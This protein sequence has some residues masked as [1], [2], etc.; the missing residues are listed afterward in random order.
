M[1]RLS[2]L[3]VTCC[4]LAALALLPAGCSDNDS[5]KEIAV[6]N[7][8]AL[9]QNVFADETPVKITFVTTGAW[10]STKTA[11]WAGISPSQGSEPGSY[12]V[13]LRLVPNATET[14]RA[15][16]ITISCGETDIT[17]N[18]TQKATNSDGTKYVPTVPDNT[19]I[20]TVFMEGGT[21]QMGR[22][23]EATPIHQVTLG[24]FSI[25]KYPVTQGQ[26]KTVMETDIH[27]QRDIAGATS[28]H[29][30]GDNYPMYYVNF[31]D[32]QEFIAELN[33]QTGKNY[34]LPTE[35]EWEYAAR[36]GNQSPEY[37]YSGSNSINDV[38]WHRSNG[39]ESTHPVGAKL[40]NDTG[41]YDMSGNVYEWC[42]DWY[43]TY[44]ASAQTNPAGPPS[45]NTRALRGG[46][47]YYDASDCRV[48]YRGSGGPAYRGSHIG[49][50]IVLAQ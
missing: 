33:R 9:N 46:S 22:E 30:E 45:G 40:P 3:P 25:G 6:Q 23:G 16:A 39:N 44:P 27:R 2:L 19:E 1:F 17:V 18:I 26:W 29:G 11:E 14:D 50:R 47:W 48:A 49:F 20:E 34:R 31:D 21:F 38:A 36:G 35:A 7:G 4:L 13:A 15:A 32:V 10:I 37:V 24:S 8:D 28:L 42:S 12:T 41:I 43:G 5:P